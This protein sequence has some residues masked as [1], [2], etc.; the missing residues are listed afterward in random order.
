MITGYIKE[1]VEE[2]DTCSNNNGELSMEIKTYT[3]AQQ[4]KSFYGFAESK[5]TDKAINDLLEG[6][7]FK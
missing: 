5:R 4:T 6:Y 2:S 3:E 1:L 7:K